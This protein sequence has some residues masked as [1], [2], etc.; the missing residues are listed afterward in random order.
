M[1]LLTVKKRVTACAFSLALSAGG[2]AS[3]LLNLSLIHI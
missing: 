2:Q 3:E 1:T